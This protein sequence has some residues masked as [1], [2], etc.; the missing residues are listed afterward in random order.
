[1]PPSATATLPQVT[2][3]LVEPL[4]VKTASVHPTSGG[5]LWPEVCCAQLKVQ[6]PV[7]S[8]WKLSDSFAREFQPCVNLG[9]FFELEELKL[10]RSV[11]LRSAAAA[12]IIR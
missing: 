6:H 3:E 12:A 2:S 7:V 5:N 10:R 8:A 9:R 4:L 1:M 11:P